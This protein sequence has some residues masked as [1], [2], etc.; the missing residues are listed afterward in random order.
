MGSVFVGWARPTV[1]SLCSAAGSDGGPGPPYG[2]RT[3]PPPETP[4]EPVGLISMRGRR[5]VP[6]GRTV[7]ERSRTSEMTALG[8]AG[9]TALRTGPHSEGDDNVKGSELPATV[10]GA[11]ALDPEPFMLR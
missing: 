5:C 6:V 11:L 2:S 9:P 7:T 3:G 10:L 1:L 8:R 4:H